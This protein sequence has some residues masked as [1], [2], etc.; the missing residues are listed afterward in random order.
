MEINPD[1]LKGTVADFDIKIGRKLIVRK[2]N[3]INVGFIKK[4]KSLAG[5]ST[6]LNVPNEH[7]QD[8]ILSHDIVMKITFGV[9][10][11]VGISLFINFYTLKI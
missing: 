5:K 8:K 7:L 4:L 3:M 2:G 6:S 1:H 11:I 9:S 10:L